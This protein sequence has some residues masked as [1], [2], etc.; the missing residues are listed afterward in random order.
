[1]IYDEGLSFNL[2][3]S[4]YSKKAME[5]DYNRGYTPSW[6]QDAIVTSCRR[7]LGGSIRW[8]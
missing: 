3:K 6:Y 4:P 2:V 7:R 1:M 8:A 5:A